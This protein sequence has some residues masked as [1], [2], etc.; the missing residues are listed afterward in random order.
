VA[1]RSAFG[2]EPATSGRVSGSREAPLAGVRILDLT[3]FIAGPYCT[4]LLADL[5][6]EVVK[7]EPPAG[8]DTRALAPIIGPGDGVSAYFLRYNRSKKSVAVALRTEDGRSVLELLVQHADALVENFRPGVLERLG[9][10]WP[11]LQEL[12]PRLVYCTITGYGYESSPLRDQGAFTP[13]VEAAAGALIHRSS[14]GDPSIAGYPVGDIFPAS[15]AVASISAALYRRERDGQ[16]ARVDIAMYD[17]MVSLNERAI[18]MSAMVGRDHF[19][20]AA[21]DMGSAPTG[22]YRATD[23]YITLA[24]VGE[25]IWQRFCGVLER[26]DWAVDQELQSGTQRSALHESV[27]RPG[28]QEWLATRTREE[29]V[30][31]LTSA[32]VPAAVAAR[33]LEV[34]EAEQAR[35]R[36]MIVEY[37]T[38]EGGTATVVANPM[39]FG[40]EPRVEAGPAPAVGEHTR[41][42]LA[43]WAGVDDRRIDELIESGAIAVHEGR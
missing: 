41:S 25:P 40:G 36:G 14:G 23:G 35:A 21:T 8:E 28:I 29:A 22:V 34:I 3:R 27:I 2:S 37:P 43:A 16:G 11:R 5:G 39:R 26:P 4:M 9:F 7:V 20:G 18:G 33:P 10:D 24:V 6:A 31:A 15:L 38:Y 13:I 12:N 32:G 42:V 1:E 19:P 30:A 17:A